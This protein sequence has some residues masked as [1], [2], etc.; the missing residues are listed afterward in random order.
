MTDGPTRGI[1]DRPRLHVTYAPVFL[2]EN[3]YTQESRRLHGHERDARSWSRSEPGITIDAARYASSLVRGVGYAGEKSGKFGK[4]YTRNSPE[5]LICPLSCAASL[6]TQ[7][8][9]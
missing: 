1:P 8:T 7:S 4:G 9:G 6:C 2:P 5:L 3:S